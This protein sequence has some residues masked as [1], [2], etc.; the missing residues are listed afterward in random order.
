V[1]FL[2]ASGCLLVAELKRDRAADTTDLQALKY[3]AFCSTMTVA[4]VIEEYAAF[5]KVTADD[6]RSAVVGHAPAVEDEGLGSIRIRLVAGSF[7]PSVTSVVQW[8]LDSSEIDIGCVQVTVRLLS[9]ESAVV[10]S[11]L[12]LPV[13][14]T[15]NYIVR[16]RRREQEQ[17]ARSQRTRA[18][19]TVPVLAE[20]GLIAEGTELKLGLETLLTKWRP[21]VEQLLAKN[22]DAGIA[23]WNGSLTSRSMRWRVDGEVYSLTGLTKR[24]LEEAGLHPPDA[25]AGPD[26]WLLPDGTAMY[27]AAVALRDRENS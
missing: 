13:P 1:L 15:E 8:L 24:V 5:H 27:R 19:N 14:S 11:R 23:E 21:A 2:D 20:A 10:T 16:R 26:H 4:E 12:V 18:A 9:G 22:P 6:A 17:Q 25:V 7:G 3:A